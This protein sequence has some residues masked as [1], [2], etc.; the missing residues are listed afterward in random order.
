MP[1]RG[2]SLGICYTS[3]IW[4]WTKINARRSYE[5]KTNS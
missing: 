5:T 3:F 2:V 1:C 4:L